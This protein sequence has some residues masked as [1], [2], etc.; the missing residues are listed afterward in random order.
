MA[1]G[2]LR[3][4]IRR[5]F[6]ALNIFFCIIFLM[7]CLAP[8]LNPAHWWLIG[9]LG[10]SVP[11]L[12]ILLI[13]SIIFWLIINPKFFFIP[14]IALIL[15][16][17]Q[18]SVLFA[19]HVAPEFNNNKPDSVLRIV[20]WNVA[21]MYG[22][23]NN[24]EI[25]KHDRTEIADVVLKLDPDIICLQEF[26]DS[27]TQGPQADNIALFKPAYPYYNFSKDYNKG[28]GFYL[29]GSIIF[30]KFPI[31]DSGKIKYPGNITESL[32]YIDVKK[33]NDTV[34]IYTAHLQSFQFSSND[35][36]DMNKIKDQDD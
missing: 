3:K 32:I 31:I 5:F 26:N 16:Y 2:V 35:Y 36:A 20:D 10:L 9:F 27:Y 4:F 28:N 34:R 33:N 13:F 6:I 23:S 30:S 15:G 14:L 12:I 25:K 17:K 8:Y 11:Y 22:L 21:S 19:I 24:K 7:A 18:L 29:S 1:T